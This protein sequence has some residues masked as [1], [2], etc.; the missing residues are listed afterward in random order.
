MNVETFRQLLAP[1]GQAALA[2]AAALAPSE[3]AFLACFETL[4]KHYPAEL[5]KAALEMAILRVKAHAKFTDADRMYFTREALEQATSE[6][7]ARH[8]CARGRGGRRPTTRRN[9]RSQRRG[10]RVRGSYAVPRR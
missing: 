1:A 7:V 4:R 8:R 10:A 9:G 6:A 3:S 2:E 5:V